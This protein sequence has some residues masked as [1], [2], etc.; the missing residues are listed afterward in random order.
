MKNWMMLMM[1]AGLPMM[2]AQAQPAL[3]DDEV[4]SIGEAIVVEGVQTRYYENVQMR[5]EQNGDFKVL[6]GVEKP[7]ATITD[8]AV[9]ILESN[10]L[11]A[12]LQ[13]KGYKPT[14]CYELHQ[15]VT[16]KGDTFH[17]AL[18]LNVLQTL[19]AC[20]QMI[21]PFELNIPLD[22]S[23]LAPGQYHVNVNGETLDFQLN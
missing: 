22:V 3:F 20:V 7:L 12:V 6:G 9:S 17:V 8:K 1:L 2:T 15:S 14:P 19:V 10:P 11:Q 5:I 13:L 23:T 21:D 16:R 18:S 4:L